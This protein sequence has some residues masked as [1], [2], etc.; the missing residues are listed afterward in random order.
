MIQSDA[1]S[2]L[3]VCEAETGNVV[4]AARLVGQ[5]DA[6]VSSL[7]AIDDNLSAERERSLPRGPSSTPIGL[8]PS[9]PELRYRSRMRSTSRLDGAILHRR[10]EGRRPDR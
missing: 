4:G 8:R 5:S 9:W 2:G 6:L 10:A 3:A 1:L 7:G